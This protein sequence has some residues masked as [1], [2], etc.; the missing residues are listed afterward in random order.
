[1]IGEHNEA[2]KAR[3]AARSSPNLGK[4]IGKLLDKVNPRKD[5]ALLTPVEGANLFTEW[6]RSFGQLG[7]LIVLDEIAT[8]LLQSLPEKDAQLNRELGLIGE[9][10]PEKA[11]KIPEI[12]LAEYKRIAKDLEGANG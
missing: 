3:E 1:M 11:R 10:G 12:S 5:P 8:L 7:S 9:L 2:D 4:R 6:E